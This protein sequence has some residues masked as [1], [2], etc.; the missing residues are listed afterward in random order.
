M[1]PCRLSCAPVLAAT[2]LSVDTALASLMCASASFVV[3]VV[4]TGHGVMHALAA[5]GPA[6]PMSTG[7]LGSPS[8]PLS[9]APVLAPVG[10]VEQT[11]LGVCEDL[12]CSPPDLDDENLSPDVLLHIAY[13]VV[14]QLDRAEDFQLLSPDEHDL[15]DFVEDQIMSL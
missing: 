15:R 1:E 8:S 3:E 4:P 14:S 9:L 13:E 10:L 7:T 11:P 12:L 5:V 2:P 6:A